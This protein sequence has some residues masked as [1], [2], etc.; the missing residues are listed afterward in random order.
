MKRKKIGKILIMGLLMGSLSV[1]VSASKL[2]DAQ[3]AK[4]QLETNKSKEEKQIEKLQKK[5]EKLQASIQKLD[6]QMTTLDKKLSKLNDKFTASKEALANTREELAQA[7]EDEKNQYAS[8]KT[9]IKYM[10][11]NGESE[12]IDIIFQAKSIGD[13]LNRA[14]YVAKISEYDN[15]MLNRLEA[16]REKIADKEEQQEKEVKEVK[17]L[18]QEVKT[19]RQ[20]LKE[21][22]AA[23][24]QQVKEF[25]NNIKKR[26][27]TIL[28]YE[29][30]IT[31][32]EKEIKKLEEE[33]RKK[34]EE[35]A[36]KKAEEA[37]K[38]AEQQ[39]SQSSNTTSS[40]SGSGS[41]SSSSSSSSSTSSG[42]TWPCPSSHTISSQFGYRIHPILGTKKL[43]NGIDI[44]APY[45]S[46]IVAAG[47]GTVIAAS[48]SSSMGNYVM[49]SHGNGITTVYMHCSSLLVSSGQTVSK[50]QQIARVGSTGLSTGNH[51]HFSVMKNGSYVSPWDYL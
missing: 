6:K 45:G 22:A 3:E 36:R 48:Y 5:Q 42:F 1:P 8:M 25:Q 26:K 14:E 7:K 11:E 29:K 19:Q 24:K 28:A 51:L 23:K 30:Q 13:M 50:G 4:Q 12:Y 15:N 43:H 16:T 32:Q 31:A 44:A 18:R 49:I 2:S 27:A 37:K 41:S 47:S 35:E 17:Q 9:R 40:S 21:K 20:K 39:Q 46:S 34:A 33:A 10:Y 38:Q